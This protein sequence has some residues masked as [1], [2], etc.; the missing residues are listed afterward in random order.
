MTRESALRQILPLSPYSELYHEEIVGQPIEKFFAGVGDFKKAWN[1]FLD[2][3]SEHRETR[4]LRGDGK[5]IFV[6]Y[7]A[8]AH[9][10]P[11]RHLAV[12]RNIT[13]RKQAEAALR[14]REERF[15]E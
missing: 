15:Q 3:T 6:E 2:R 13:R 12:L 4:V 9:Y 7:T 1:R 10:L 5:A 11:G 8:K 14:E